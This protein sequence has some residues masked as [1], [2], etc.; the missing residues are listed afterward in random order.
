MSTYSC[1]KKVGGGSRSYEMG[2]EIRMKRRSSSPVSVQNRQAAF[3][4]M[5]LKGWE[6]FNGSTNVVDLDHNYIKLRIRQR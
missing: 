3:G 5:V 6:I 1:N 2:G 4:E